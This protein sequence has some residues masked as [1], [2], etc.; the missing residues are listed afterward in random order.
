MKIAFHTNQ[1]CLRG[2]EIALFDYAKFNEEILGHESLVL[3]PR[4]SPGNQQPAIT[5][6]TSR[7]RVCAYDRFA[8]VDGLIKQHKVDKAYFIKSGFKDGLITNE[9]ES[10][11]HAMFPIFP[12]QAHGDRFAFVSQWLAE[13]HIGRK[14][15]FVPHMIS[16]PQPNE[17]FRPRFG[18]PEDALVIGGYGG[19][20]SFDIK[21]AKA[22]V[23]QALQKRKDVHFLFMNFLPFIEHERAIFLPG[24]ADLQFKSNFINAC[25]AMLHARKGG[26]SFGL[27][28]G[29]FSILN[30]PVLTYAHMHQTAHIAILGDKSIIYHST[31]ELVHQLMNLD[32]QWLKTQ[33]WDMYSKDFAPE[34]VM[35]KFREV[36]L[37]EPN[38][39][40]KPSWNNGWGL[41]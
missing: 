37:D 19:E 22:A 20:T 40:K 1:L 13:R 12:W 26:E 11:V 30:K 33:D 17:N 6:F 3:Y 2:S 32:R 35:Q 23:R 27:A 21:I 24:N 5:K 9:C 18:L 38:L 28:C 14:L 34:P 36:F 29:E 16:L 4:N 39:F 25:D 15:P 7:F 41:I 10:L 8:E 31:H